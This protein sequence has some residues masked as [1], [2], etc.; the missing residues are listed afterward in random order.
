M[1]NQDSKEIQKENE[2]PPENKVKDMEEYDLSDK[3]FKI[4]VLK[5]IN[6]TRKLRKAN[7]LL[8]CD[9]A[10]GKICI[11]Q[12]FWIFILPFKIKR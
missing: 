4:A 1:N 5:K 6:D 2:K 8:Y 3:K 10:G 11:N 12:A 7:C 9:K